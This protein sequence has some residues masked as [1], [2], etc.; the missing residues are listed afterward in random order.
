MR[1]EKID[2]PKAHEAANKLYDWGTTIERL[3]EEIRMGGQ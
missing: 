1:E 3:K 2:Y